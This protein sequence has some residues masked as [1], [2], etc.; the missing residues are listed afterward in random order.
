MCVPPR[1]GLRGPPDWAGRRHPPAQVHHFLELFSPHRNKTRGRSC[2]LCSPHRGNQTRGCRTNPAPA[3]GQLEKVS[4]TPT[5]RLWCSGQTNYSASPRM[6]TQTTLLSLGCTSLAG[7]LP[8]PFFLLARFSL[9]YQTT[10]RPYEMG[11]VSAR[12]T[13]WHCV[14]TQLAGAGQTQHP[15]EVKKERATPPTIILPPCRKFVATML[16]PQRR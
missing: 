14:R 12:P 13:T 15:R 16:L 9:F 1:L 5:T 4:A 2:A 11:G 10:I 7:L 6:P 3:G 8:P